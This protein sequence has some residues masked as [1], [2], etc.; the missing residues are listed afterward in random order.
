MKKKDINRRL[1]AAESRIPKQVIDE[2]TSGVYD[3]MT[4]EELKELAYGEPTQA[5]VDEIWERAVNEYKRKIAKK[6]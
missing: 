6:A 3:C 1:D 2:K 5:R 4:I